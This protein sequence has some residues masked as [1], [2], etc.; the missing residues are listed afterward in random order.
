MALISTSNF[1]VASQAPVEAQVTAVVQP[2][3]GFG[4]GGRGR[5][6]HPALGA[7]DYL[8]QP[9]ETV[10]LD[11]DVCYAPRWAHEETLGGGADVLWNGFIR[12][13]VV[14]E[15]WSEGDVG[16]ALA[17]LR[18][19]WSFY[20]NPPDLSADQYVIWKPNYATAR[21]YKVALTEVSAGGEGYKIDW[22]LLKS[23][24]YAPAPVELKLRIIGYAD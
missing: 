18:M 23:G 15:R 9:T 3:L 8:H 5:L 4:T 10:N 1:N 14:T 16:A 2:P 24:A 20:T 11:G 13:A 7:Y 17:H 22:L 19:L 12:D 6:E 21:A